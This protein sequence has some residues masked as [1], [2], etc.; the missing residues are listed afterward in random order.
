VYLLVY[1]LLML[2]TD[3]HNINVERKMSVE[4][5]LSMAKHIKINE[6]DNL[7]PTYLVMLYSSVTDNPLSVHVKS[8]RKADL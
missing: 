8:K 7:D 6:K 5:F 2:Q 4:D 1:S 3:A